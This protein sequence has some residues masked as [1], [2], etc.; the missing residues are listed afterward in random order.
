MVYDFLSNFTFI[1]F[2]QFIDTVFVH[3]VQLSYAKFKY[4]TTNKELIDCTI[5]FLQKLRLRMNVTYTPCHDVRFFLALNFTNIVY[6]N[7]TQFEVEVT[8]MWSIL[9]TAIIIP[10]ALLVGI[11]CFKRSLRV[12]SSVLVCSLCVAN[13]LFCF[14]YILPVKIMAIRSS[15][16]PFINVYCQISHSVIQFAFVCCMNFH[17]CSIS[18]E[19]FIAITSPFWYNQISVKK[20]VLFICILLICW[21][22]PTFVTLLPLI[23]GWWRICPNFCL[24]SEIKQNRRIGL[25]VWNIFWA[26]FMFLLPTIITIVFYVRVFLV[27]KEHAYRIKGQNQIN[28]TSTSSPF[29]IKAVKTVA[30]IVGVYIIFQTPYNIY[31]VINILDKSI[32]RYSSRLHIRERLFYFASWNCAASPIIYGYF[33]KNL[34]D[35]VLSLFWKSK[36]ASRT[37][38]N[39]TQ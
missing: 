31:Q 38:N 14:L 28:S 15:V 3:L 30:I 36:T 32:Q 22:L 21:I 5:L 37:R 29:G 11:I 23:I 17:I 33:N 26:F 1:Y 2:F 39:S 4:V 25:Q 18:L 12:H 24:M 20:S 10:N 6:R 19:K 9:F 27:A 13:I 8:I 35:G 34:R 16:N 7:L